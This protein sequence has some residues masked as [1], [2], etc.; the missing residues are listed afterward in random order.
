MR[1]LEV[2][3]AI[4]AETLMEM[5]V[6]IMTSPEEI[7]WPTGEVT[8]PATPAPKKR[9]GKRA[10]KNKHGI[11]GELVAELAPKI[12]LVNSNEQQT[13]YA[14]ESAPKK[15]TAKKVKATKAAETH[16]IRND[17]DDGDEDS[18]GASHT[19]LPVQARKCK[20]NFVK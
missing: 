4:V 7:T 20:I 19:G 11:Y 14:S 8:K 16:V 5:G 9:G 3:A 12:P 6:L 2:T 13:S 18:Q 1:C 17:T 10:S 15:P